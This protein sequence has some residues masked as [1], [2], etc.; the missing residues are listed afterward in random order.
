MYF[1]GRA[2]ESF[3]GLNMVVRERGEL[4]IASFSA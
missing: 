3:G 1:E 2:K 4:R